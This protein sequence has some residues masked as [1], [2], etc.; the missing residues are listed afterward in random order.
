MTDPHPNTHRAYI[1]SPLPPPHPSHSDP[2]TATL[3]QFLELAETMRLFHTVTVEHD[4]KQYGGKDLCR[5]LTNGADLP[6]PR[7]M[8]NGYLMDPSQPT[9]R[10]EI[11][12]GTDGTYPVETFKKGVLVSPGRPQYIPNILHFSFAI[13]SAETLLLVEKGEGNPT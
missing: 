4:G 5:R 6:G 11:F 1:P 3:S 7:Y 8:K 2:T 9:E 10:M 13:V 12:M